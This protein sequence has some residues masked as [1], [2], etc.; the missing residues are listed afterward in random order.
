MNF[1]Q[2]LLLL[3]A[4]DE[5]LIHGNSVMTAYGV[6]GGSEGELKTP[7][8]SF[9]YAGWTSR[10]TGPLMDRIITLKSLLNVHR[11]LGLA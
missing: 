7:Q 4:N 5:I 10:L 11:P 6:E 9:C 2:L 1:C 8:F 3:N